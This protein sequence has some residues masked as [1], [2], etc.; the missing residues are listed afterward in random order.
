MPYMWVEPDIFL[1]YEGVTVYHTYEDERGMEYWYTT[2][3]LQDDVGGDPNDCIFDVRDAN[4][5]AGRQFDV[6]NDEGRR[7]AIKNA[8]AMG[9]LVQDEPPQWPKEDDDEDS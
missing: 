9:W 6:N 5:Y 7:E 4:N 1:E 3:L 2:D 8:I